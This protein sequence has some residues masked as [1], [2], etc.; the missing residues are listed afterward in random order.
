MV[1]F[2]IFRLPQGSFK[3]KTNNKPQLSYITI[4]QNVEHPEAEWLKPSEVAKVIG[5][6]EK[7]LAS[8]REGKKG[9]NGPPFIKI[10]N[11]KT[12][13]I[14]YPL[15]ELIKWMESFPLYISKSC[16]HTS[17]LS[18]LK[19]SSPEDLWP[20]ILYD[21]GTFEDIFKSVN[22]GRFAMEFLTRQIIWLSSGFSPPLIKQAPVK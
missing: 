1:W 16:R 19:S 2:I 17:Y 10:G 12:S 15:N 4:K 21:D 13:P 5:L 18:F 22:S 9:I 8:A 6:D 20:F 11:G 3:M 7:W 14:R